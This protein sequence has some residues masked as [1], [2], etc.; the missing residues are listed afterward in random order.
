M[1]QRGTT[2][3]CLSYFTFRDSEANDLEAGL[4]S[5]LHL[6][7]TSTLASVTSRWL[8]SGNYKYFAQT[9]SKV[10]LK[11]PKFGAFSISESE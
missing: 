2:S 5:K 11:R 3:F 7:Q 9:V 6:L 8:S 10:V 1:I 4:D